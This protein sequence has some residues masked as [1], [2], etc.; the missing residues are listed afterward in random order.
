M[1][2]DVEGKARIKQKQKC[3]REETET[4]KQAETEKDKS[5]KRKKGEE[6][7]NGIRNKNSFGGL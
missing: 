6:N 5:G 1:V 7:Q 2:F 3:G 4:G